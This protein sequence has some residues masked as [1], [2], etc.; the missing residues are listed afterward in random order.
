MRESPEGG[1]LEQGWQRLSVKGQPA[2][3]LGFVEYMGS[4]A[5]TQLSHCSI[6]VAIDDT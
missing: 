6:K 2:N 3:I 5:K 1:H 4:V